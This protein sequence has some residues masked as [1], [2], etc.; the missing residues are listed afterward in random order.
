MARIGNTHLSA[1]GQAFTPGRVPP[2]SEISLTDAGSGLGTAGH[3]PSIGLDRN[4][5]DQHEQR[6]VLPKSVLGPPRGRTRFV[7]SFSG[8]RSS[9]VPD[10]TSIGVPTDPIRS[11]GRNSP[12]VT[13]KMGGSRSLKAWRKHGC[14]QRSR[15]TTQACA[16]AVCKGGIDVGVHR[17]QHER[18]QPA[19]VLDRA[20]WQLRQVKRQSRP[21]ARREHG[22]GRKRPRQRHQDLQTCRM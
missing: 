21:R 8:V 10:A 11:I 7:P 2:T 20:V 6:L 13:P 1:A 17:L 19:R 18:H 3:W 5:R 4:A 15:N 12:G 14:E 22:F 16:Q 9:M